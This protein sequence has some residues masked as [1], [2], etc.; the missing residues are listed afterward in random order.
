MFLPNK[1]HA[2]KLALYSKMM[3]FIGYKGKCYHFMHY[4]QGN[5]IFCF[6][7]TIFD[8]KFFHKYTNSCIKE[9][10]LYDKLLDR[11]SLEIELS[12]P[13]PSGENRLALVFI[14]HI[15]ICPIQMILFLILLYFLIDS[16]IEI[17]SSSPQ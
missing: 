15:H 12:V 6:T 11:I 14:P 16:N 4:T 5:M 9:Y 13:E 8:E 3:V 1:I 17:Q 10:K 2:N 7:Y